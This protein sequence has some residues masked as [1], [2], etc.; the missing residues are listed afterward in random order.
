MNST[1]QPA[2]RGSCASR[3]SRTTRAGSARC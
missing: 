3:R 2:G 1:T